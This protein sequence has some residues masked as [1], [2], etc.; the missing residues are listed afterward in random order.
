MKR[1]AFLLA[2][3]A[4]ATAPAFA[5]GFQLEGWASWVNTNS[6]TAFNSTAP[7]QPFGISL[8]NK[9]GYGLG[10]DI[11]WSN[12][13]STDFSAVE[14]RPSSRFV[15]TANGAVV[16]GPSL[17]MTP[18]TAVIQFHFMP[19]QFVDPYLGGGASYV[20][21]DNI[22]G[23]GSLGVDKINFK[24]DVGFVA[25]GG[26]QFNFGRN[27]GLVADGK[28]VPLRASTTAVYTAG[29]QTVAKF[30]INPAIFSAG[31]ALHF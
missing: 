13:L 17:R 28:Y 24:H 12:S 30:K 25:N 2:M 31:L 10:A 11:F 19:K 9:V 14:V 8:H 6:N 22:N 21:F 15:T 29:G 23:P 7:N 27:W 20:L 3:A 16:S 26:V 5:Q 4:L 18:L 1:I